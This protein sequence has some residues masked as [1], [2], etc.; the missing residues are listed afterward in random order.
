MKAFHFTFF[1]RKLGLVILLISINFYTLEAADITKELP[2]K[3]SAV[4][5][6]KGL[7][8]MEQVISL[9]EFAK[10]EMVSISV[11]L[12]SGKLSTNAL[13]GR[14]TTSKN[15]YPIVRFHDQ[16]QSTSDGKFISNMITI[17]KEEIGNVTMTFFTDE[18]DLGLTLEG[19]IRFFA[20][21]SNLKSTP[22]QNYEVQN[23]GMC[24]CLQ[25]EFVARTSWGS[26]FRLTGNIF[27]PPAVYTKVSHLIV[28]HSAGGN[29]S[30]NWTG[31][32]A[33]I[34]DFHVNTN[35]WS[36][37]GY[38][39]LI[40]PNGVIY[41][42]RGGGDNV[43]GAHMCGF[44]SNTMGVCMLG[45][46]VSIAPTEASLE[47]LR[48][49]LA[50]KAC[51][52]NISPVGTA[53][54]TSFPGSMRQISGHRDG[55]SPS[56]T[57]CPGGVLWSRLGEIRTKTDDHINTV[58]S[59]LGIDNEQMNSF[60]IAPNP[61]TNIIYLDFSDAATK[62]QVKIVNNLGQV[63]AQ[64]DAKS[65]EYIDVSALKAGVYTISHIAEG[66]VFGKKII[67][68]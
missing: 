7:V 55:C 23:N 18:K 16:D 51:K 65:T 40:D 34:F 33:S 62:G 10:S 24:N 28:H 11:L 29:T 53:N 26:S 31:V 52:E 49:L 66:K 45:N 42:G 19:S 30:S 25:P 6:D 39:W 3:M 37:T 20:P 14:L 8:E 58:C 38:N 9:S 4:K 41:E 60:T 48:K 32:V 56:A 68:L 59:P 47:A 46:Y 21:D 57:E 2:I 63:V 5:I 12:E 43:R 22:T 17:P 13:Y 27:I 64:Y 61:A 36:D 15:S 1:K 44:N 67:K 35:G 50:W 54:I